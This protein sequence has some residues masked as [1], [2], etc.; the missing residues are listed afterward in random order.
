MAQRIR[1]LYILL[2]F[3]AVTSGCTAAFSGVSG[4]TLTR[5]SYPPLSVTAN[6]PF[7]LQ[8]Q[9]REWVTFESESLARQPLG[10]MDYAVYA[11]E[12]T[13]PVTRHAHAFITLPT[14]DKRWEFLPENSPG[15][16]VLALN[17]R[18][19][20][21]YTGIEQIIRVPSEGDWFST[22]WTANGRDVPHIWLARRFMATPQRFL[23]VIAEYREPWPDCL[24]TQVKDLMFA[25]SECLQGFFNRSQDVFTLRMAADPARM[26]P[27]ARPF[28]NKPPFSANMKKLAGELRFIES[29][30]FRR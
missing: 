7:V 25:S 23:R 6:A 5:T 13:G 12:S 19:L 29:L 9:G 16:N 24:D 3:A 11:P 17:K 4:D 22:L 26:P 10:Q 28:T 27:A 1:T 21:G 14:D 18:E 20:N 2:L 8:G 15:G 30:F